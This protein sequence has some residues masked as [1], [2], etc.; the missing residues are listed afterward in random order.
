MT[1]T[2]SLFF[3]LLSLGGV[4][5]ILALWLA[6]LSVAMGA[7][8]QSLGEKLLTEVRPHGLWM[9]AAI[10]SAAMAGSLYYSEVAGYR[11]CQLCWVQRGFMYPAAFVL[12]AAAISRQRML[13]WLGT[14]LAVIGFG[15]SV[16]HRLEQQFPDS[17]STGACALDNP[18]SGRYVEWF[19]FVTIP[20]MAG[21]CFALIFT[22]V[23][24]SLSA[25]SPAAS[26]LP[27]AS[28]N[29]TL[30]KVNI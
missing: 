2:I 13:G 24:L 16:F 25:R 29:S 22:L 8:E 9:G 15:V 20:T 7:S 10:A 6:R 5:F 21:V 1:E 17:V 12:V 14:G 26:S 4:V 27:A 19:G 23:P 3:A 28:D 18:C 30:E 11:P